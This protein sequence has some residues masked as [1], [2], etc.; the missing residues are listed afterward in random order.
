MSEKEIRIKK[1]MES[2]DGISALNV[3]SNMAQRIMDRLSLNE[4]KVLALPPQITLAV[5]AS[6]A[7]LICINTI[8]LVQYNKSKV[9]E[10]SGA[11][12]ISAEYFSYTEQI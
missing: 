6:I 5:A 12:A 1:T 2:V 10:R 8:T 3:P 4:V 9:N 11:K 7:L